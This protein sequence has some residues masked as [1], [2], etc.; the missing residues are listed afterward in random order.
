[1][2]HCPQAA[3]IRSGPPS[4]ST[5]LAHWAFLHP[6]KLTSRTQLQQEGES[7]MVTKTKEKHNWPSN[8]AP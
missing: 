6:L 2:G 7:D 1:M 5:W 4:P 3:A 8:T